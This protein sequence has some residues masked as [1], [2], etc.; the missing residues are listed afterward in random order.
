MGAIASQVEAIVGAAGMTAWSELSAEQRQGYEQAI[1]P[2]TPPDCVAYPDST[3]AL[4]EIMAW[5]NRDGIR[6]LPCGNGSKLSWGGLA[7]GVQVFVSTARLNRI[8]DH[9]VDDMVVVAEAGIPVAD[10][11]AALGQ[12]HQFLS[13]DP[14]YPETA[15]LGGM[16][17]TAD[18]GTLR[19]RYGGVRDLLIGLSV[20]RS[21]GQLAKAGGKVVKNVAGY[22]LM[23]LMTGS[24][25]TLGILNS[26]TFRTYPIPEASGTVVLTGEAGAIAQLLQTLLLSSLTPTAVELLAPS[27]V[28]ALDVGQGMGL[29]VRFQ[30]MAVSVSQQMQTVLD[31][32]QAQGVQ[33]DCLEPAKDS[34]PEADL[35][36]RLREQWDA[37]AQPD[38]ITCKIGI[39]PT[40][41]VAL[42]QELQTDFPPTLGTI[43][44]GSGLGM[45]HWEVGA[46]APAQ[47]AESLQKVRDRCQAYSGFLSVLQATP[48]LKTKLQPHLDLWG[49][50]AQ[51]Q[52]VMQRLKQRF[53]PNTLL[54]PSRLI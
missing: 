6:L 15:T 8:L 53:D 38:R 32:A 48:T 3:N 20:V 5:A 10:L 50:S 29:L 19:H 33:G 14:A 2:G 1:A 54:S 39:V 34:D 17:A 44:A 13:L 4:S 46:I 9:A 16:V 49:I 23:K 30:S 11:Q 52:P 7:E 28:A 51:T 24:Y 42:L 27:T 22:D 40:Q 31:M 18:S 37:P 12:T 43:H 35:W 47:L 41:A 25:G 21:D 45:L 26:L 36:K